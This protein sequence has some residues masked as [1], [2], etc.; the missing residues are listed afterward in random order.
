MRMLNYLKD[1]IIYVIPTAFFTM[2]FLFKI[3]YYPISDDYLLTSVARGAYNGEPDSHLLVINIVL[4][5]I[6]ERLYS[7]F[8]NIEWYAV[9]IILLALFNSY[10]VLF[11]LKR[12]F[13]KYIALV[14]VL[15]IEVFMLAWISFTVIAYYTAFTLG[16]F[17][18]YC[19][20]NE[21]KCYKSIIIIGILVFG[22]YC[23]REKAF[24]SGIAAVC[25][26]IVFNIKKENIK[27]VLLFGTVAS[28]LILTLMG[29]HRH[30]YSQGALNNTSEWEIARAKVVDYPIAE[31]KNNKA[32]YGSIG[33]S[34]NDYIGLTNNGFYMA[35][36]KT[37]STKNLKIIVEKTPFTIRHNINIKSIVIGLA[38]IKEVWAFLI[39]IGVAIWLRKTKKQILISIAEMGV[40]LGQCLFLLFIGR[41]EDREA[42][43]L[44]FFSILIV[45]LAS[46]YDKDITVIKKSKKIVCLIIPLVLVI[47]YSKQ[48]FEVRS[49]QIDGQDKYGEIER[50]INRNTNMLYTINNHDF[51]LMNKPIELYRKPKLYKNILELSSYEVLFSDI[52]YKKVKEYNLKYKNN[53]MIDI[54]SN[55]NVLFID[56]DNKHIDRIETYIKEHTGKSVMKKVIKVFKKSKIIVYKISFR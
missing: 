37:Y 35:D 21:I 17:V 10:V 39:V 52:Y 27:K 40:V 12:R 28:L 15:V 22:G 53:L 36:L 43:P 50:Y 2:P 11:I 56:L 23:F 24:V 3:V 30:I 44:L 18:F 16:V 31:Y 45:L 4:S 20:K 1:K 8:P 54:A 32:L 25:P 42:V 7:I 19:L 29:V 48:L 33:Y 6:W 5:T 38:K 34:E 51:I 13:N 14:A 55:S 46:F 41:P 9:T 47:L 49:Y 26:L